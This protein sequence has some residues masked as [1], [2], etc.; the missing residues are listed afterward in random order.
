MART[1]VG[2]VGAGPAGIMAALEAARAGAEVHLYDTNAQVGRK[3]LVTG[4]G[5]CNITNL[6]A[7]PARYTCDQPEAL[8]AIL[9]AWPPE[10]VLARL[11]EYGILTYATGDGWCYPLSES[12]GTVVDALAAALAARGV[13]VHLQCHVAGIAPAAA[14]LALAL[15]G[16]AKTQACDRIVVAC[17]GKAYPALGSRGDVFPLLERLGHSV[18]PLRPALV[19]LV[20]DMRALRALQGVRLDVGLRL[21]VDGAV[22]AETVGNLLFTES[23]FSGP[24]A[25]DVSHLVSARAQ[26][27]VR[28]H[29]DLLPRHRDR[30]WALLGRMRRERMPLRV[31]LGAALPPKVAPAVLASCGIPADALLAD[32]SW[33]DVERA[34]AAL[35]DV[36]ARVTG[37]RGFGHAQVSAGGV[38]LAEVDPATM[39]SRRVAGMHLAGEVLDAIGP[40]GGY[41]LQFAWATGAIAGEGAGAGA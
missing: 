22:A 9:A 37:T 7:A 5:R 34:M 14:G 36:S 1:R 25:M 3:L 28:V 27:D 35:A 2:V 38:P 33:A 8:A 18:A 11:E 26:A 15:G 31:V 19:P 29:L 6:A 23:G 24:A 12:A 39:Q 41:N 4:N 10:R 30:V 32:L 40:C 16:P 13:A 17:G 20:A 21:E